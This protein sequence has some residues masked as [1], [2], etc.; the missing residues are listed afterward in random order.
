MWGTIITIGIQ[1][2]TSVIN[3]R[4]NNKNTEKLKQMQRDFRENNLKHALSR[5]WD[6]FRSLC[7]FQVN[8]ETISHKERLDRID[9]DFVDSLDRWA[10][11]DAISSHYPL[12]ISPYI[13]NKSVIPVNTKEIGKMRSDIFC[14]LTGSNDKI[15]NQEVLPNID[16]NLCDII[17]T[18]FCV[19]HKGGN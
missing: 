14:I 4:Y 7:N 16:N 8:I 17:S 9:Q 6:R 10:H 5:D 2:A 12:R 3:Q 13:I 18:Y 11:A 15:F 19:K 1:I